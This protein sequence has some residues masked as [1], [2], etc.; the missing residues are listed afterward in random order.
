MKTLRKLGHVILDHFLS[1][2]RPMY[3]KINHLCCY[4][5][6]RDFMLFS[7]SIQVTSIEHSEQLFLS[8]LETLRSPNSYNHCLLHNYHCLLL[9]SYS[10]LSFFLFLVAVLFLLCFSLKQVQ[11]RVYIFHP[12]SYTLLPQCKMC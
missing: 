12:I 4:F 9:L 2:S 3:V 5:S 1:N 11:S 10:C 8:K 6:L 7:F